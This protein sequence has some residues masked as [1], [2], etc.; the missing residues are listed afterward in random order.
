MKVLV[1]SLAVNLLLAGWAW[2]DHVQRVVLAERVGK[3]TAVADSTTREALGRV[4]DAEQRAVL[5]EAAITVAEQEAARAERQVRVLIAEQEVAADSVVAAARP[6]DTAAV[7]ARL[8]DLQALHEQEREEWVA[9]ARSKDIVILELRAL[10]SARVDAIRGLEASLAAK[11]AVIAAMPQPPGWWERNDQWVSAA[12]ALVVG[13]K[14]R[15]SQD[16]QRAT[17]AQVR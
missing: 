14:A 8:Q 11:D 15:G 3:L 2:Y 7:R 4:A 9:V 12:A 6:E 17:P 16:E 10:D 1:A 5:A 13:W